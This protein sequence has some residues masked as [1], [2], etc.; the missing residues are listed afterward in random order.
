M[1]VNV[2]SELAKQHSKGV[3]QKDFHLGNF[4]LSGD[5]IFAIDPSQIK[6]YRRELTKKESISQ[7][8]LLIP[9]CDTE[10]AVKLC[11][12]YAGL[13]GWEFGNA[14]EELFAK[15]LA[16]HKKRGIKRGLK[17]CL[18]TNKRELKIKS[19]KF[20]AVFDRVFCEGAEPFDFIKQLDELMDN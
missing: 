8:A 12:Q 16:L 9:D 6:F 5:K 4:L 13:R 11:R 10:S 17:K 2:L 18:R 3:L 1:L 7:L 20:T 19:D 15:Y 14:E